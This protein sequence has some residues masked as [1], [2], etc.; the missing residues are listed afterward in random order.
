MRLD[1][2][3]NAASGVYFEGTLIESLHTPYQLI[4]VFDTPTLGKLMRIDGANMTSERDEFFYHEALVHPA[5]ITH[6]SPRNVL[7]VGGGDGGSSEEILKHPSVERVVLAELDQG[8]IDMAKKYFHAV[9]RDVFAN[10]KLD[11]RIGDGMTLVKTTTE[12][13]DLIYLDLTD[14]IGSAE[15][16]YTR[17]FYADC[18]RALAEGGALVL[19]IGSPFS[20]PQRVI[21]SIANLRTMFSKTTPYFVHIPSYGATWG[22]A[23]ASD[24]TNPGALTA[25]MVDERLKARD[26]I[27][28]QHYNG[29]THTAMLAL[30]GYIKTLIG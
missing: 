30:P 3:L 20:H 24:V 23:V 6:A 10:P 27:D 11:V 7:I 26:V 14:P 17:A 18:K 9:H 13:F 12:R 15:M 19:H 1:E 28:R 29:D 4:E 22:F 2:R 25:A 8:V 21:D 5:A 16:L